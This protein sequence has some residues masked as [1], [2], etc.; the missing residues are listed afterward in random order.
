MLRARAFLTFMGNLK[1]KIHSL[2]VTVN[3]FASSPNIKREFKVLEFRGI[4]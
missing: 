1:V 4:Y 3:E 2:I